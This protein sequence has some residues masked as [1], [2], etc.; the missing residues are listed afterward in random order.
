MIVYDHEGMLACPKNMSER[1]F[2]KIV[3]RTITVDVGGVSYTLQSVPPRWY[4]DHNDKCGMTGGS[5]NRDTYEYMDGMFRNVVI[6]PG[7]V[8]GKGMA[9][10]DERDDIETPEKLIRVIERFLRP[11]KHQ[12]PK[13]SAAASK[14]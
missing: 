1:W 6:T 4:Y 12:R 11:G 13:E 10:F 14:A 8:A 7:E 5:G 2:K 9:Y 3:A